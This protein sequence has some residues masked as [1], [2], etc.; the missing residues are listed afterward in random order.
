MNDNPAPVLTPSLRT[1]QV[2]TPITF[3]WDTNNGNETLCSLTGGGISITNLPGGTPPDPEGGTTANITIQGRTTFTLTC[4]AQ[5]D[6][7]TIDVVP[8]SFES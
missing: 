8:Q 3:T 6:V 4:G 1:V 7:E 5:V 2:G